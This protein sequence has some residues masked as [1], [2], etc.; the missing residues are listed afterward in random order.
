MQQRAQR[1][2]FSDGIPLPPE[3]DAGSDPYDYPADEGIPNRQ[4]QTQHS[5]AGQPGR[6]APGAVRDSTAPESFQ[7]PPHPRQPGAGADT[8]ESDRNA[9]E[10]EMLAASLEPG[11]LDRRDANAIAME[12]LANELGAKPL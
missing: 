10:E 2:E 9:E 11:Q 7:R 4:Q 3:P 12:L 5:P 8:A 1:P 6:P